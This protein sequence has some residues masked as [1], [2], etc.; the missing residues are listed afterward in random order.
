MLCLM[1][2]SILL[3]RLICCGKNDGVAQKPKYFVALHP[4]SLRRTYCTSHSSGLVRLVFGPF[5][6]A[7]LFISLMTFRSLAD[8]DAR[9]FERTP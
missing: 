4:L 5:R 6:L 7:I 9:S 3:S 2:I 1:A 8:F